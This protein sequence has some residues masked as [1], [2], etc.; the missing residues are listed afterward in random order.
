MDKQTQVD[1]RTQVQTE[2]NRSSTAV[3]RG[4]H[5]K[6]GLFGREQVLS[7]HHGQRLPDKQI[8]ADCLCKDEVQEKF[9]SKALRL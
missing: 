8:Q 3:V 9:H 4:S 2:T 7:I 5:H 1:Q 6:H